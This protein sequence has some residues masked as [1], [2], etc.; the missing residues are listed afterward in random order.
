LREGVEKGI[1]ISE[2]LSREDTSIEEVRKRLKLE[3]LTEE[4]EIVDVEI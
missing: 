1:T 4:L 2:V 3:D